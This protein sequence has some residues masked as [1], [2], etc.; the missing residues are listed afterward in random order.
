MVNQTIKPIETVYN[1]YRFRSRLE[2]RWAVF[3][4][5]LGIKYEYE[6]EGYDL[7]GLW[8]LPDFWL[9]S[10]PGNGTWI[11]VK[12]SYP[13]DEIEFMK[14]TK[15][16]EGVWGTHQGFSLLVG[17]PYHDSYEVY[18]PY[19]DKITKSWSYHWAD[20]PL[21]GNIDLSSVYASFGVGTEG[22]NC[23]YCDI[24]N[25]DWNETS[26]TWFHKGIVETRM[27]GYALNSPRLQ[28]AYTAARQARFGQNG[29]G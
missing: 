26:E 6:K 17:E 27:Q 1:G 8:Y 2:A 19:P 3:F 12:P 21:C 13:L 4:D 20:C 29:R 10:I 25:R 23:T 22:I 24:I 18:T 14:C 28:R 9:P 5:A 15:F 16:S 7:D 11:E